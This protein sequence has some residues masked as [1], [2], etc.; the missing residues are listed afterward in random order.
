MHCTNKKIGM[1]AFLGVIWVTFSNICFFGSD[2]R[3]FYPSSDCLCCKLQVF[4]FCD[5]N[6]Q[7]GNLVFI[8]DGR[9]RIMISSQGAGV[10]FFVARNS[11]KIRDLFSGILNI[12]CIHE[13]SPLDMVTN[14]WWIMRY[15]LITTWV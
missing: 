6:F 3:D 14:T 7:W 2:F 13:H 4:N 12:S 11:G 9:K 8:S 10:S 1:F 5:H 15:Q